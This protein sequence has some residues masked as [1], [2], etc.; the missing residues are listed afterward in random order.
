LCKIPNNQTEQ[1]F[2]YNIMYKF[3]SI[4]FILGTLFNISP[5]YSGIKLFNHSPSVLQDSAWKRYNDY[6]VLDSRLYGK[7]NLLTREEFLI[8]HENYLRQMR[9]NGLEIWSA[10]PNDKNLYWW[11]QSTVSTNIPSYY[12]FAS[13]RFDT[14]EKAK[15]DKLYPELKSKYMSYIDKEVSQEERVPKK[16]EFERAELAGDIR[17]HQLLF[18]ATGRKFDLSGYVAPI[19]RLIEK[20]P[21]RNYL[22]STLLGI[23]QQFLNHPDDYGLNEGE[24]VVFLK[25]LKGA[26]IAELSEWVDGKFQMLN[27]KEQPLQLSFQSV[28]GKLIDIHQMKGK[29]ILIDFWATWCS[30]CLAYMP[31]I[32][33]LYNKYHDQGLEVISISI[34]KNAE[35]EQVLAAEKKL[36]VSWPLGIIGDE[37]L[38]ND[39]W[40]KF[41][42]NFVPQLIL[43]D[44]NGKLIENNGKL[45]NEIT[46]N[47]LL[48]K[49]L[50]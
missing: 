40:K 16:F 48:K 17:Y 20:A 8:L 21:T 45:M 33:E 35:K 5:S 32:R 49:I 10:H 25:A 36:N 2:N 34:N 38:K 19:I 37:K 1:S 6:N 3:S 7:K 47:G 11:L 22:G 41:A 39:I 27:L 46:L 44:K 4:I 43:L 15:W 42:F 30:T 13:N 26:N 18:Q 9:V 12:N 28:D 31:T 14:D 29:I 50:E 23:P 24:I